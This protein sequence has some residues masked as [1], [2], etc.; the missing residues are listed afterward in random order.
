MKTV[1]LLFWAVIADPAGADSVATWADRAAEARDAVAT[2]RPDA[3]ELLEALRGTVV[4]VAPGSAL[5]VSDPVLGLL[6]RNL[7]DPP[8]SSG[9]RT[10]DARTASLRLAALHLSLVAEEGRR[11]AE[12]PPP[13]FIPDDAPVS[14]PAMPAPPSASAP[15]PSALEGTVVREGGRLRTW[16]AGFLA[17]GRWGSRATGGVL[18]VGVGLALVLVVLTFLARRRPSPALGRSGDGERTNT[19][20]RGVDH[21]PQ[22]LL[23]LDI[24]R[25]LQVRGFT[26]EVRTRT[27]GE[28]LADLPP[29]LRDALG[30]AVAVQERIAYG[31]STAPGTPADDRAGEERLFR[32]ALHE[33]RRS[34]ASRRP[35]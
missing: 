4:E 17:R 14:P 6:A 5:T 20:P 25:Q 22:G 11:L 28:V 2:G 15:E 10:P 1:F 3:V 26:R 32:Q 23:L 29:A 19:A 18:A 31:P 35:R 16:M 12:R 21:S 30:P 13:P 27:N 7:A 9:T 34:S 24:F 33:A 8:S